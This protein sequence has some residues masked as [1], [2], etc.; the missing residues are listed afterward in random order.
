MGHPIG[1]RSSDQELAWAHAKH[2]AVIDKLAA[3]RLWPNDDAV[4]KH[5]RLDFGPLRETDRMGEKD[6]EV[7]GVVGTVQERI[8]GGEL[9]PDSYVPF[10][11]EYRADMHI[12]LK[13]AA[14][15]KE[16]QARVLETVRR[17]IREIDDGLHWPRASSVTWLP[18]S[19]QLRSTT[20]IARM[21]SA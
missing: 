4:G 16:V 3:A 5:L 14:S 21:W 10:G 7:V 9:R 2:V 1:P 18:L 15:G 17:Q 11:P 19:N 6:L 8:I 12:H 20:A 13:V